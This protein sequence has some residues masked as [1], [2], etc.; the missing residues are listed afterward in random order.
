MSEKEIGADIGVSNV[1]RTPCVLVLDTSGSMATDD[2]IGSLNRGLEQLEKT[3][4]ATPLLRRQLLIA[5][6]RFSEDVEVVSDWT[7]AANF[8]A[9]RLEARGTTA[10]GKGMAKAWEMVNGIRAELK[11]RGIQH[12]RPW[13]FLLSDGSPTDDWTSVAAESRQH[14]VEK[15]AVVWPFLV[16][17]GDAN[18]AATLHQFAREDMSV[19]QLEAA[20]FADIFEWLTT[21]LGAVANSGT[22]PHAQIAPPPA[23]PMTV[24]TF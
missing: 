17:D 10:M 22:D 13:L 23:T 2:R 6:V 5:V 24:S 8:T 15:R 20:K 1:Q 9:P 18:S 7:E 14:C 19:Y 16:G 21:S 4:K 12:T 11:S 3:V